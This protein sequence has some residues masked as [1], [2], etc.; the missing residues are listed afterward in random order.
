MTTDIRT[1]VTSLDKDRLKT[2]KLRDILNGIK[3]NNVNLDATL[4]Y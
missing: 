4:R 1:K 2:G 3:C